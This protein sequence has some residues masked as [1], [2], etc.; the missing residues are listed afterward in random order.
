MDRGLEETSKD[1]TGQ[2]TAS[3]DSSTPENVSNES[4]PVFVIRWK[5][6]TRSI[7]KQS[8][9]AAAVAVAAL[10]AALYQQKKKGRKVRKLRNHGLQNTASS[11]I[12]AFRTGKQIISDSLPTTTP[13]VKRSSCVSPAPVPRKKIKKKK[14]PKPIS[15]SKRLTTD[16]W[17][18]I[19]TFMHWKTVRRL[20]RVDKTLY[21]CYNSLHNSETV[22][23]SGYSWNPS[24]SGALKS[25][26][27]QVRMYLP[28]N[29]IFVFTSPEY[30]K[31]ELASVNK[32]LLKSLPKGI[33]LIGAT[34]PPVVPPS[35][36]ASE[37]GVSV[38]AMHVPG[39]VPIQS[40]F[41]QERQLVELLTGSRRTIEHESDIILSS[42]YHQI[43]LSMSPLVTRQSVDSLLT[44][45]LVS[46]PSPG[47]WGTFIILGRGMDMACVNT[48]IRSLQMVYPQ[49]LV[50]GGLVTQEGPL[51]SLSKKPKSKRDGEVVMI[52]LGK[53]LH[54]NCTVSRGA[55]PIGGTYKIKRG[56]GNRIHSAIREGGV[57]ECM[58]KV[59]VDTAHLAG[60]YRGQKPILFGVSNTAGEVAEFRLCQIFGIN[61]DS[62]LVSTVVEPGQFCQFFLHDENNAELD[63]SS[64][65]SSLTTYLEPKSAHGILQFRCCTSK[66]QPEESTNARFIRS[67]LSGPTAGMICSGELG[68]LGL[69]RRKP[70]GCPYQ[71]GMSE[72]VRDLRASGEIIKPIDLCPHTILERYQNLFGD[73]CVSPQRTDSRMLDS[74]A[75]D[76]FASKSHDSLVPRSLSITEKTCEVQGYTT[77]LLALS[78][79]KN[80]KKRNPIGIGV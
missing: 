67:A 49:C 5:K 69:T 75:V 12:P 77:V 32:I 27:N 50:T 55:R 45:G 13:H 8:G 36:S 71:M 64:R 28:P 9:V 60:G 59:L 38:L 66:E 10:A 3:N 44:R 37:R 29:V 2:N 20:S 18:Y 65:L 74:V 30:S 7:A 56:Y 54:A 17:A 78:E 6:S 58:S 40:Y 72:Q 35:Y 34:A 42:S 19:F 16:L 25:V 63:L 47:D 23:K 39:T 52:S 57:E 26:L 24:M 46:P 51:H 11:I 48:L 41:F 43:A 53:E 61:L 14:P 1:K 4:Q 76:A 70:R 68:P 21:S 73:L 15:N 33:H 31:K 22:I 80:S 79:S 62:M